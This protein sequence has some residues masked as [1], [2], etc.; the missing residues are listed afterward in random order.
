MQ[1]KD[2]AINRTMWFFA[3]V[4]AVEGIGQ[5]RTGIM[6]AAAVILAEADPALDAGDDQRLARDP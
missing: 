1:T 3:I 6:C 5:A 4:Y 2:P